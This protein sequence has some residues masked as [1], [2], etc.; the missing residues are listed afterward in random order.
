MKN[1]ITLLFA[2]F[3]AGNCFSQQLFIGKTKQQVIDYWSTRVSDDYFQEGKWDDTNEEY[4]SIMK[5]NIGNP[6]FSATFDAKGR[7][8]THSMLV[9]DSNLSI[10]RARLKKMGYTYSEKIGGYIDVKKRYIWIFEPVM[11]G[12]YLTCRKNV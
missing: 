5:G 9:S 4:F 2:V 10:M 1:I 6:D 12:T 8:N 11:A 7:C 3:I